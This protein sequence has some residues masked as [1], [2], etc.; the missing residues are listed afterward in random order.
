MSDLKQCPFCG[1]SVTLENN[2]SFKNPNSDTWLL[3]KPK[4]EK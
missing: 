3:E 4:D 2:Q 1:A